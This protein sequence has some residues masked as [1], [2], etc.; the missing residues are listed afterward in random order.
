MFIKNLFKVV[1][2]ILLTIVVLLSG[3]IVWAGMEPDKN[4]VSTTLSE[5]NNKTVELAVGD[6]LFIKTEGYGNATIDTQ[7]SPNE[8]SKTGFATRAGLIKGVGVILKTPT[9]TALEPG[10][11]HIVLVNKDDNDK[12]VAEFDVDIRE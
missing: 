2:I 8:Y 10:Q 3:V 7:L 1:G 9:L 12:V 6:V 5:V 4:T 11:E